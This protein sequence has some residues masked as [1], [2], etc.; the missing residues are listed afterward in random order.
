MVINFNNDLLI[1]V[2]LTYSSPVLLPVGRFDPP[3]FVINNISLMLKTL[4]FVKLVFE[5]GL[6]ILDKDGV[7][8]GVNVGDGLGV[9]EGVFD[10][11]AVGVLLTV[12]EA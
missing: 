11:V 9:L 6:E 3:S 8:V 5:I 12:G 4:K 10:G 2:L 1:T 7:G